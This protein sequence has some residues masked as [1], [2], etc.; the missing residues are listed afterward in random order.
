MN[1][2]Y[3][4]IAYVHVMKGWWKLI[5]KIMEIIYAHPPLSPSQH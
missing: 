1:N 2:G 4:L 5:T 3:V